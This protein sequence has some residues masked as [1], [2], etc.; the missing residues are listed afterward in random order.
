MTLTI[1]S[2]NLNDIGKITRKRLA[3]KLVIYPGLSPNKITEQSL[4]SQEKPL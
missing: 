2:N 4:K 3:I 1:I